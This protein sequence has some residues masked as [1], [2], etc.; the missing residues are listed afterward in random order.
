[1]APKFTREELEQVPPHLLPTL[2]QFPRTLCGFLDNMTEP[3]ITRKPISIR[4]YFD[5]DNE[6]A[7]KLPNGV[8]SKEVTN[9]PTTITMMLDGEVAFIQVKGEVLL[10]RVE[11]SLFQELKEA[12][13]NSRK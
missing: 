3:L 7:L 10:K 5:D 8:A 6:P 13:Q 1:M 12:W 2:L 9:K 11:E 4:I